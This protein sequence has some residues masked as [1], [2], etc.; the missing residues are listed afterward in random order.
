MPPL[1]PNQRNSWN[2]PRLSFPPIW[3]IW[4]VKMINPQKWTDFEW[5]EVSKITSI[6][7]CRRTSFQ[8]KCPQV[9]AARE[10]LAQIRYLNFFPDMVEK[11]ETINHENWGHMGSLACE[12]CGML[13]I[14]PGKLGG[15]TH[16][17]IGCLPTKGDRHAS[18][19]RYYIGRIWKTMP[20]GQC[21]HNVASSWL[22]LL[23]TATS[24]KYTMCKD[25]Q[26]K[27]G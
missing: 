18:V 13:R 9:A 10:W 23:I 12:S 17:A 14:S 4:V 21:G 3:I 27:S 15:S 19:D 11:W 8:G 1:V 26:Q 24:K 5:F 2:Y 25:Q 6:D 7:I 22:G 20:T 16:N